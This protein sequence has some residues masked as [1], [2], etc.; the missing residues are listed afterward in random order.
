[1][2]ILALA[3]AVLAA[4]TLCGCTGGAADETT[5]EPT[6]PATAG[7]QT[8]TAEEAHT[9]MNGGGEFVLLD[10]RT[11]DE[12]DEIRIDGAILIPD[13]EIKDRAVEELPDKDAVI[14]IYCR[15]GRRSALAAKDLADMGYV[16]V[17][18]FGGIIDWPYDTVQ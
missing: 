11:K 15:S 16:N 10:V 12:F 4:L 1:M 14:L 5:P 18:D 3:L 17:Y 13:S 8:I 6:Q 9:M 7:Y 2:R